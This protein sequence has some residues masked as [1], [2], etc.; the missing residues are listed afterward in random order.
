MKIT[1]VMQSIQSA[2]IRLLG[3]VILVSCST[4]VGNPEDDE[5]G[6]GGAK[7]QPGGGGATRTGNE[8][9]VF[10]LAHG[11]LE[12]QSF[13]LYIAEL[14]V[15]Q[16]S[17]EGDGSQGQNDDTAADAKPGNQKE[18]EKNNNGKNDQGAADAEGAEAGWLAVPLDSSEPVNLLAVDIG[19]VIEF[20]AASE[21]PEGS[22]SQ[23][24][25][26]LVEEQPATVTTVDGEVVDVKIPS[27]QETGVKIEADFTIGGDDQAEIVLNMDLERS[28]VATG[29]QQPDNDNS[30]QPDDQ[31]QGGGPVGYLLKPVIR[32]VDKT[33]SGELTAENVNGEYVC[34][35]HS[36]DQADPTSECANAVARG[37][38]KNNRYRLPH[39]EIGTYDLRIFDENGEYRDE[40]G[41]EVGGS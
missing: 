14:S 29:A 19:E 1:E 6:Q 41:V 34:V 35:Y 17:A 32:A 26:K 8:Q 3:L 9:V 12:A 7:N 37:K 22:Y 11:T 38:I 25:L 15:K 13:D 40:L 23:I 31:D 27:G 24:R 18:K 10:S 4:H 28:L 30:G 16:G 21:L 5:Q 33:K 20:A 2:S 36:I 39:L